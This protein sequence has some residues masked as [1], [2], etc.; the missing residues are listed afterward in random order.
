MD[1]L[2]AVLHGVSLGDEPLRVPMAGS[3]DVLIPTP[4]GHITRLSRPGQ[5][6]LPASAAHRIEPIS[7]RYKGETFGEMALFMGGTR[8]ATCVCSQVGDPSYLMRLCSGRCGT[9][10]GPAPSA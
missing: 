9:G 1:A 8:N 2:L 5:L 3:V 4:G 7:C 10:A 6:R